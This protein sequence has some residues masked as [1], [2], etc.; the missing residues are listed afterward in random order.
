MVCVDVAVPGAYPVGDH[1]A[2][3]GIK[4]RPDDRRIAWPI[5]LDAC[6]GFYDAAT[7]DLMVVLAHHIFLAAYV[8]S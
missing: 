1:E 4:I 6:K 3:E 8:I 7:L 5:V 2:F